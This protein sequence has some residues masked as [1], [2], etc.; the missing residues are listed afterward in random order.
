MKSYVYIL[1]LEDGSMFKIGKANDINYRLMQLNRTW[2][3]FDIKKAFAIESDIDNVFRLEKTLHYM[4]SEYNEK[5]NIPSQDGSTEFFNIECFDRLKSFIDNIISIKDNLKII[6]IPELKIIP[7]SELEVV[8]TGRKMRFN[9][10]H[11]S[12]FFYYVLERLGLAISEEDNS[13]IKCL[14]L[15]FKD[16]QNHMCLNSEDLKRFLKNFRL[17][18]E[19]G[20]REKDPKFRECKPNCVN[21][22]L[23]L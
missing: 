12:L 8:S 5:E 22:P 9:S 15:D 6:E 4:F 13:D 17:G 14:E 19:R 18:F 20:Y 3:K 11:E 21:P 1:P 7:T 16:L 2:G 23:I 10:E